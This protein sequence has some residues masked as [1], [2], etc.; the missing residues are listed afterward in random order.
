MNK[1]QFFRDLERL[2]GETFTDEEVKKVIDVLGPILICNGLVIR[3]YE[4][5]NKKKTEKEEPKRL[6]KGCYYRP[7]ITSFYNLYETELRDLTESEAVKWWNEY[8]L[9]DKMEKGNLYY[10]KEG[11]WVVYEITK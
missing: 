1:E 3:K 4:E 10:K 9:P 8:T 6:W 2:R 7:S 11:E 5:L